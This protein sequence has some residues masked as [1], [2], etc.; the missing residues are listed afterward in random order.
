MKSD[1]NLY[2]FT[3]HEKASVDMFC[4][5]LEKNQQVRDEF[6]SCNLSTV[7]HGKFVA[8]LIMGEPNQSSSQ[9]SMLAS[10]L[11]FISQSQCTIS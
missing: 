1:G 11:L 4:H 8:E 2:R 10:Q 6:E 9:V 7:E 3:Q 5:L